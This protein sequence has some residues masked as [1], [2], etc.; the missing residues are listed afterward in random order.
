[1][2]GDWVLLRLTKFFAC[3][4]KSETRM[5][6]VTLSVYLCLGL[7]FLS[8]ISYAEPSHPA[9]DFSLPNLRGET[10][11][12]SDFKGRPILLKLGTTWCPACVEQRREL[13]L[14]TTEL[15]AA[16]VVVVEVYLQ[17]SAAQVEKTVTGDATPLAATILIDDGKVQ[18]D[19][20]VYTIPR[21]ILIGTDFRVRRDGSLLTA[22]ELRQQLP[23]LIGQ[24]R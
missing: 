12:L 5:L 7:F 15:K 6:K 20:N 23:A 13:R 16:G 2:T 19:Y 9:A 14:A 21:V 3:L 17:E 4:C 24:E 18:R 11:R 22:D 1:M 10:V 8:S